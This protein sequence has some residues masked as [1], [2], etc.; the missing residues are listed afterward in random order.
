MQWTME[1][2]KQ[3]Y[4][5]CWEQHMMHET[6]DRKQYQVVA[7]GKVR[8]NYK[9]SETNKVIYNAKP[10]EFAKLKNKSLETR[11]SST[12]VA[13]HWSIANQG[14]KQQPKIHYLKNSWV[15]KGL[16]FLLQGSATAKAASQM[17][18][19]S[20]SASESEH[21]SGDLMVYK[22]LNP[23]III[24]SSLKFYELY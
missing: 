16:P 21:C 11:N 2:L 3:S 13:A 24:A 19:V 9:G 6:E 12:I 4:P 20:P 22:S 10:N 15:F 14:V 7:Q 5:G 17:W 8:V 23:Q 1:R 18:H